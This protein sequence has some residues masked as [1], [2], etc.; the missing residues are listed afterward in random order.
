MFSREEEEEA[1]RQEAE[2]RALEQ[3]KVEQLNQIKVR[4][5]VGLRLNHVPTYVTKLTLMV[6]N[7]FRKHKIYLHF[8]SCPDTEMAQVI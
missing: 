6:L 5:P 3:K 4:N 8:L 7:F 2:I 1:A